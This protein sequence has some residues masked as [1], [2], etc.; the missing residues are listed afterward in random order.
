MLGMR[1]LAEKREERR[2]VMVTETG[3]VIDHVTRRLCKT[4]IAGG[5]LQP[6]I[7]YWDNEQYSILV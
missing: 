4:N 1:G 7:R 6:I 2:R 3:N 5:C